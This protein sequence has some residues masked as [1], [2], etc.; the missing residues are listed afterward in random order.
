MRAHHHTLYVAYRMILANMNATESPTKL[1]ARFSVGD[2]GA[3]DEVFRRY[4]DRVA[5][6]ARHAMGALLRTKLETVDIVQDA[7]VA[8]LGST[9]RLRFES[10][11]A[12]LGWVRGVVERR[13][14]RAARYWNAARRAPSQEVRLEETGYA[15]A[16][17]RAKTPSAILLQ[18]EESA[19]LLHLIEKL[20][21]GDR[22][23]I[24]SRFLLGLPW[25]AVASR[26]GITEEAAQMR[27]NRARRRL[28]DLFSCSVCV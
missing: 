2:P 10:E 20:R 16:D 24:N 5:R 28:A 9:S 15:A 14:L 26:L 7:M 11:S 3:H 17:I 18:K 4:G 22:E 12:F 21:P 1:L 23:V 19:Q 8:I 27:F 6:I 13:I 25:E